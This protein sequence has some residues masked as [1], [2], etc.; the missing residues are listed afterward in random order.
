MMNRCGGCLAISPL[1]STS[2]LNITAPLLII[3]LKMNYGKNIRG[4]QFSFKSI[5]H[6]L[7]SV[8]GTLQ[9]GRIGLL[10]IC[11][12]KVNHLITLCFSKPILA[13]FY[14]SVSLRSGRGNA[15]RGEERRVR[16]G[17]GWPNTLA[18]DSPQEKSMEMRK[19]S[20]KVWHTHTVV[21]LQI[22]S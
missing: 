19:E 17:G 4:I 3:A 13:T 22:K 12:P 11:I 14:L 15:A 1:I 18:T 6:S 8:K 16:D 20:R 21:W 7:L 10:S 5:F 2:G 9:T